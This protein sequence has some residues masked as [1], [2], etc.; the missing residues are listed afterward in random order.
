MKINYD[1]ILKLIRFSDYENIKNYG[2]I[3]EKGI[4]IEWNKFYI[5]NKDDDCVLDEKAEEFQLFKYRMTAMQLCCLIEVWEQ[6]LFNFLYN[7]GKKE[8]NTIL[9]Q[10]LTHSK[11]T[12]S[13]LDNRYETLCNGYKTLY[14]KDIES[15]ANIKYMRK[16]VNAIKHGTGR[17][18]EIIKEELGESIL[19]DSNFGK[20]N[21]D[22]SVERLKQ[23]KND[24]NTLTSIVLNLNGKVEEAY[25]TVIQFWNKTYKLEEERREKD[26]CK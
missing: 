25:N 24:N 6:D 13:Y 18:F 8:S 11:S 14:N 3:I 10:E 15:I 16:I 26:E 9:I 1:N 23:I 12:K 20:V 19:A 21:E 5:D 4:D 2:D 7:I 17:D 22:G